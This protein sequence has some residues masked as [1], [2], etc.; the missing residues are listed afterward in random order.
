MF[1]RFTV[2]LLV[3]RGLCNFVAMESSPRF[4]FSNWV[5]ITHTHAIWWFDVVEWV[6]ICVQSTCCLKESFEIC[7]S[8]RQVP[9]HLLY[10]VWH[11]KKN[12]FIRIDVNSVA[13]SLTQSHFS[14]F[15]TLNQLFLVHT[16]SQYQRCSLMLCWS[17]TFN[18]R[19]V[20]HTESR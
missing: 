14:I 12:W 2:T 16:G 10:N 8:P 9:F 3:D 7:V 1:H 6:A 19:F 5:N 18:Q 20:V 17:D 4:S 13:T 11:W 15:D